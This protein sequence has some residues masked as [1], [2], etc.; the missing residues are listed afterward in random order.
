MANLRVK[1][2]LF[3]LLF[4][5]FLAIG[6]MCTMEGCTLEIQ[7]EPI[8]VDIN[9][10]TSLNCDEEDIMVYLSKPICVEYDHETCCNVNWSSDC[11]I[12][13]CEDCI[14]ISPSCYE[15]EE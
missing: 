8:E 12:S 1:M 15:Q 2:I 11:F 9:V 5:V 14:G 13:F 7:T 4:N 3:A 6:M 10:T